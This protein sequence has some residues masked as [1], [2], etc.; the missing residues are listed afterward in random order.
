[1]K[2]NEKCLECYRSAGDYLFCSFECAGYSGCFNIRTGMDKV[3]LKEYLK[4]K[5]NKDLPHQTGQ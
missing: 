5:A 4:V 2:D 1:M 3:K